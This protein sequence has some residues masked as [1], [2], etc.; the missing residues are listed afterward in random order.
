[1]NQ[2]LAQRIFLRQA[3]VDDIQQADLKKLEEDNEGGNRALLLASWT[4]QVQLVEAIL[5]R[6]IDIN[7]LSLADWTPIMAAAQTRS[8]DV[9]EFLLGK[10]ANVQLV[11]TS[12]RT[13]LHEA[14]K[15][16]APDYIIA[17]I[18]DAGVDASIV[19]NEGWTAAMLAQNSGNTT[20]ATYI[21]ER[22]R[23]TK[24]ANF[25]A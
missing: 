17:A 23:P 14:V 3:T 18:I 25:I 15:Q 7:E 4:G 1:M 9:V 8:W 10:G 6:G 12:K 13:V 19:D 16:G 22:C 24:S 5:N 11:T 20:L 2:N 21:K